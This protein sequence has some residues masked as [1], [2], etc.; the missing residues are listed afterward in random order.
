MTSS[1]DSVTPTRRW[2][3]LPAGGTGGRAG[4]TG[5]GIN[6]GRTERILSG[7]AGAALLAL[8]ARRWR[9]LGALL[10]IGGGLLARA[11]T[12]HCPVN[13]AIG[14]NSAL[15]RGGR[16]SP[17]TSVER[18]EGVKVE[19]RV[20]VGRSAA[21][22][23]R[24]WRDFTNLPLIMEH[25]QSVTT[26]DDRRSRWV[27]KGPGGNLVEWEAEIHNDIENELIAW[28]S[29][30]GSDVDNAGSVHFRPAAGGRGTEVRV[31][32]RY[33]PPTGRLG[34]AIATLLGEAPAQQIRADLRR[35]KQVMDAGVMPGA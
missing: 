28:R 21:E 15:P 9:W 4:R 17:V 14:R 1:V 19:E 30:P 22:L 33:D 20:V 6:V 29:L 5:R 8:G 2:D 3:D 11:V 34:A 12:G 24:F 13:R 35:F 10:P 25:L 27:A 7:I 16:Q 18:G 26:L 32:L 23:Y 31:V